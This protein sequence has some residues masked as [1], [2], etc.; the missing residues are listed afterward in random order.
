MSTKYH[1]L[2]GIDLYEPFS[3]SHMIANRSRKRL[4]EE[5]WGIINRVL[6]YEY[7]K[8]TIKSYLKGGY[9]V[10]K[11]LAYLTMRQVAIN[12]FKSK[13]MAEIGLIIN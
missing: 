9:G 2:E 5:Y 4:F 12:F 7:S 1:Y 11:N 8:T 3:N 6:E 10:R 13:N